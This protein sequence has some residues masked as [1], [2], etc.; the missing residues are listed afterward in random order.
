MSFTCKSCGIHQPA[1]TKPIVKV[2]ET[3]AVTY[4]VGPEKPPSKGSEIVSEW[5]VCKGCE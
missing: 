1:G 5:L 4:D 2:M 3:R